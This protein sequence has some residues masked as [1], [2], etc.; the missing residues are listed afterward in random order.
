[1]RVMTRKNRRLP[2]ISEAGDGRRLQHAAAGRRGVDR[3]ISSVTCRRMT[4][5]ALLADF[6]TGAPVA[7][8][9]RRQQQPHQRA[10]RAKTPA[11]RPTLVAQECGSVDRR[12]EI[13]YW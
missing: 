2:R 4:D 3:S 7:P 9:R 1:V 13:V 5:M 11:G 6:P 12:R 10:C 8:L